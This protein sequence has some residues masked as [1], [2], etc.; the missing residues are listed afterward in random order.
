METY[1]HTQIAKTLLTI[2]GV[3]CIAEILI[4][5][6]VGPAAL[7]AVPILAVGGWLFSSLTVQITHE[8]LSWWFG[9]GLI[10]KRVP[11]ND[12][13]A[14]KP[15]RTSWMDGLGIHW[16][17]FG[18]LYNV[19]GR[20][21]VAITRRTGKRFALGTDEPERL[22]SALQNIIARKHSAAAQPR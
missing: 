22:A 18:W 7:V 21:A 11:L 2:F 1:R 13:V 19:S 14:A 16:S 6:A 10:R 3:I 4:G 12:I 8:E 9:P 5:L 15:V 17:Q 20:D